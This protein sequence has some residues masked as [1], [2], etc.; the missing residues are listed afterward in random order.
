MP[1]FGFT[2]PSPQSPPNMVNQGYDW[3]DQ[4]LS[5]ASTD[6]SSTMQYNPPSFGST[7]PLPVSSNMSNQG[8]HYPT[9]LPSPAST[10]TSSTMQYNPPSFGSTVPHSVSSNISQGN[11]Y[12][13]QL[14]SPASTDTSGTGNIILPRLDPQF[15]FPFLQTCPRETA[16][17]P[18]YL[19]LL[20][21]MSGNTI[22]FPL[23]NLRFPPLQ[24]PNTANRG[25]DYPIPTIPADTSS[26]EQHNQFSPSYAGEWCNGPYIWQNFSSWTFLLFSFV[27]QDPK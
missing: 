27:S 16:T 4:P 7:V 2:D 22:S 20:D 8:N 21:L 18:N 24:P 12:P 3:P 13:T 9:Q 6:T 15:R 10:D 26:V 19:P 1:A 25:H 23:L 14:P 17:L 5:A 11:H